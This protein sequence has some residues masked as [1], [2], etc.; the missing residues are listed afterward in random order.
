MNFHGKGMFQWDTW[1]C[2]KKDTE[3]VHA[4]YLQGLRPGSTRSRYDADC[5][6]HAVSYNLLDW[7][8]FPPV[9]TP[10]PIGKTG[11]LTN[12]TGSTIEHEGKYYMFYSIRSSASQGKEQL[13]GLAVSDDMYNWTKYENNPIITPDPRWYNTTQNYSINKIVDCRDLMVV[14]HDLKAGYFGVFATRIPTE[15]LPEG[16][17]FAGA[18]S[19]D[20]KSWE[21][22]PPVLQSKENQYSIVEMPDLFQFE[23]K[24]YLTWLEDTSYGKREILGDIFLTS[25]TVYAVSNKVEGP[26]TEPED[27]ILIASM[28]FNGLSCRTVD[29]KG[30]K[31]VLYTMAERLH[32]NETKHTFG[33]LSLP[34]EI[35][36]INGKLCACFARDILEEKLKESLISPDKLSDQMDFYNCHETP[37]RWTKE[38]KIIYGSIRTT[39]SR[40]TFNVC[41]DNF[42]YTAN[43]TVY[44]GVAAGLLIRQGDNKSGGVALLDFERQSIMFCTV[45]RFQIVDMRKLKLE[46]GNTYQVQIIGNDK[47]IEVY[48][49]GVLMLQF[50]WYFSFEGRFG[51]LLDRAEGIF[52]EI[53]ARRMDKE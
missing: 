36:I 33:V 31:Y 29:F 26:Y 10:E 16:A 28:G 8:E 6:G 39:W 51:L 52:E 53:S 12:W 17:V 34:K 5:L 14:K 3:E 11:D 21:Q 15:E 22:T 42:L 9:I 40:Y 4:F 38:G 41:A 1:Y 47:F 46:Y 2:K 25:G 19:E 45:P 44:K 30:K 13:I 24:W 7:E 50:V 23:G 20:L 49:D 37:G 35:R 27:N 43:L 32:E 48:V 18:Y